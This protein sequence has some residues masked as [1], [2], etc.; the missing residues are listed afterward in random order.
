MRVTPPTPGATI[1]RTITHGTLRP[2]LSMGCGMSTFGS[3]FSWNESRS[4][5]CLAL[6]VFGSHSDSPRA[7]TGRTRAGKRA[8]EQRRQ[9]RTQ[10]AGSGEP[11]AESDVEEEPV[12]L[13]N[14]LQA[15]RYRAHSGRRRTRPG[16]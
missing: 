6:P 3:P 9:E 10:P 16:R 15:V 13:S 4:F 14:A 5:F 7:S 12:H 8:R 2:A 1:L 11:S